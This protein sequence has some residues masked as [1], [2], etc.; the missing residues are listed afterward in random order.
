MMDCDPAAKET[1][2]LCTENYAPVCGYTNAGISLSFSNECHACKADDIWK[3]T[4]GNCAYNGIGNAIR[5][6]LLDD[7]ASSLKAWVTG[8]A[9]ILMVII[10]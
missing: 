2:D 4:Q 7:S 3:Y 8:I 6:D 5:I 10:M 1:D 9:L